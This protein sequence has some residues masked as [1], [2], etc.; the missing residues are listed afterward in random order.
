LLVVID[1][2]S[3]PLID[4]DVGVPE[5]FLYLMFVGELDVD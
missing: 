3:I 4:P 2:L 1:P 5:T